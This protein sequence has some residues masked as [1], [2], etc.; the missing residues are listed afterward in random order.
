M[1]IAEEISSPLMSASDARV[2]A[3]RRNLPAE[4]DAGGGARPAED[5]R[6]YPTVVEV[7]NQPLVRKS[8][9]A[10]LLT[11]L[12]SILVI[13]FFVING[14][15]YRVLHPG[16]SEVDRA[17][18]MEVLASSAIPVRL[19]ASTG[20]LT[21]PIENYH[22]ARMALA[23]AGLPRDVSS[24]AMDYLTEQSTMTTSQ[25]MEEALYTAAIENELS[26]SIARISTVQSARVHIAA[27]RQSN[28]IRNKTPTKA[29][30]VVTPYSGRSVSQ[31][32][33]EAIINLVASSVP[34]LATTD[35]SVV[36]DR[37]NLLTSP[38]GA[39]TLQQ[40]S[41]ELTYQQSVET[42]YKERIDALLMPLVGEGAVTTKVDVA[43]DFTEVE[44]TFE[45]YDQNGAGPRSRSES[46][47]MD[48]STADTAQG[49]PGGVSNIVPNDTVVAPLDAAADATI[50]GAGAAPNAV[51]SSETIRNYELDRSVRYTRN[52]VGTLN[53][54]SVAIAVDE[55]AL[56]Q[57]LD[58]PDGDAEAAAVDVDALLAEEVAK[59]DSLVRAAIGF[60]AARGDALTIVT[61]RFRNDEAISISLPWHEQ[62][63]L[64][65]LIK[66]SMIVLLLA[67]FMVIVVRPVMKIYM[68]QPTLADALSQE[69]TLNSNDLSP[70][71]L[72]MLS[73]GDAAGIDEIKAKLRPKKSS[74]SADMLDTANTYDDK[75]AL[76]RLLVAEDSA[77][78]ANVLKKLIKPA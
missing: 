56:T 45:E 30:V 51:R 34:Y 59:L 18:A 70:Q 52:Q 11:V 27:P 72:A 25:F 5:A 7:L 26:R 36:D 12:L 10:I 77:R 33:V 63:T 28:F 65:A 57:A 9:P 68:P 71:E 23:A 69:D 78:V 58:L 1:A 17:E 20:A 55:V 21:V 49:I 32:Q 46:I 50:D 74:I 66:Y 37:G 76:I 35:V 16:M 64:I 13:V 41:Q 73:S 54:L 42:M 6:A 31:P 3:S 75:V 60:D 19:D 22:D 62:P 40:A 47:R 61:S 39:S 29:S 38:S 43:I 44:S 53:R 24:G 48:M 15:D 67:L 2:D 4:R 8:L 14:G